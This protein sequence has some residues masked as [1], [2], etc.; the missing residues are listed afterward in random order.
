MFLRAVHVC[1]RQVFKSRTELHPPEV[2]LL[3]GRSCAREALEEAGFACS[4]YQYGFRDGFIQAVV[5]GQR[6]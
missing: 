3:A 2:S 4:G 5:V 1:L 6:R